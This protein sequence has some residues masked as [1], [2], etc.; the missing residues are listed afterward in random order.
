MR[1]TLLSM[2]VLLLAC[3]CQPRSA[4]NTPAQW[5]EGLACKD[6]VACFASLRQGSD[7]EVLQSIV[8]GTRHVSPRVRS[9]CARLLG[10][11]QDITML[12]HLQP[13]LVDTDGAVRQQAARA[14]V[15]LLDDE[16]LLEMLKSPQ[17]PMVAR[18][19]LAHAMLRDPAELTSRPVLDWLLDRGHPTELR[20]YLYGAVRESHSPCFGKANGELPLLN[21]VKEARQ[22]VVEQARLDALNE[23]E[24]LEV[25]AAALQLWAL[26]AGSSSYAD[27]YKMVNTP[28]SPYRLREAALISLGA[29]HHPQALTVLS[30]VAHDERAPASLRQS[31]LLGLQQLDDPQAME[32]ILPLLQHAEARMRASAACAL[33][34]LGDKR[35]VEP[36]RQAMTKELDDDALYQ[37][38]LNL[39]GLECK[40]V[41][42]P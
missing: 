27:I 37:L 39:R 9:Q 8:A 2:T 28:Q 3:G 23:Q 35:A 19:T 5:V 13:M 40:G 6:G 17:C 1:A 16:E 15:P 32:V 38:R 29:S 12:E 11:R 30:G 10:M 24:P 41:P 36:M 21:Q 7:E 20:A 25:R 31:A 14:L 4:S 26:F 22:R 33:Y 42:C 34:H 18:A